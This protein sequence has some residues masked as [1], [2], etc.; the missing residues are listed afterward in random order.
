MLPPGLQIH[1]RICVRAH[2]CRVRRSGVR[3]SSRVH[4]VP[5]FRNDGRTCHVLLISP[6]AILIN[7][8]V[9][10]S[11]H[12][13]MR[14]RERIDDGVRRTARS[15]GANLLIRHVFACNYHLFYLRCL[16]DACG[17]IVHRVVSL[18]TEKVNGKYENRY[19]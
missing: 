3:F 4:K 17:I 12:T 18:C 16:H 14:A 6:R 10:R 13:S 11:I 5:R 1:E 2:I 7:V 9:H 8:A 19:M 15:I